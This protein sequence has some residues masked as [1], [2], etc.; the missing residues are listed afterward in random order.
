MVCELSQFHVFGEYVG[1]F[2]VTS[3][4]LGAEAILE[5]FLVASFEAVEEF[6]TFPGFD[7]DCIYEVGIIVME[8]EKI[9]VPSCGCHREPA[10]EV[11]GNEILQIPEVGA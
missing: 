6:C 7:G 11:C 3:D 10:G 4:V 2:I 1:D 9:L 5:E 8:D